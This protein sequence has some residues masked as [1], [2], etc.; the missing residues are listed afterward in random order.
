[1]FGS[2]ASGEGFDPRTSDM[3]FIVEFRAG[4]ELG[5]WLRDYFAFRDALSS[6][7]GQRVDLVMASAMK[8]RYFIREANR[9]RRLVYGA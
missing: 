3:D 9:T 6:L 1:M 2:A 7:F 8:K 4:Q 5:P